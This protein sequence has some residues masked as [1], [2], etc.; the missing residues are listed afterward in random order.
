MECI[1]ENGYVQMPREAY[2]SLCELKRE[3]ENLRRENE[4]L[5]NEIARLAKNKTQRVIEV[6]RY[7][8][9]LPSRPPISYD[10]KNFDDVKEQAEKHYGDTIEDLQDQIIELNKSNS[11]LLDKNLD[12]EMQIYKLKRRN[13]WQ[14]IWNK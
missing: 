9:K 12:I 10:F 8:I 11:K 13:L 4:N 1:Y 3:N 7:C 5:R 6:I 2:D 14:R